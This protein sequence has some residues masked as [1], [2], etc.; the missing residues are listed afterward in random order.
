MGVQRVNTGLALHFFAFF[1]FWNSPLPRRPTLSEYKRADLR[2]RGIATQEEISS[3]LTR[4]PSEQPERGLQ[5][6]N[7]AYAA[8]HCTP[9]M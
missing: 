6:G 8:R 7:A 5:S 2:T 3:L 1:L 4:T 9:E